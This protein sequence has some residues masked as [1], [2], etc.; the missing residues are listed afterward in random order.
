MSKGVSVTGALARNGVWEVHSAVS[1]QSRRCPCS[2]LISCGIGEGRPLWDLDIM[3][4]LLSAQALGQRVLAS[5]LHNAWEVIP[6]WV[7]C[8]NNSFASMERSYLELN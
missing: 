8:N 4:E 1:I 3:H 7:N 6:S 2:L 5:F